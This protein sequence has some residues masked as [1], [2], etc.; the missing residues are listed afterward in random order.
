MASVTTPKYF[1][2]Y[3]AAARKAAAGVE[4]EIPYFSAKERSDKDLVKTTTWR[5]QRVPIPMPEVA[6]SWTL[7]LMY[8]FQVLPRVKEPV[9]VSSSFGLDFE[10]ERLGSRS[11]TT[12]ARFD[13][14]LLLDGD[15]EVRSENEPSVAVHINVLQ[16]DPLGSHLHFP[17]FRSAPWEP[18]EIMRWSTSRRLR[19]DLSRRMPS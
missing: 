16:K 18:D 2:A 15:E 12:V 7:Y 5:S 3:A 14:S 6:G 9:L 17:A 1:K 19:R 4:L 10:G 8:E 13:Y 11:P